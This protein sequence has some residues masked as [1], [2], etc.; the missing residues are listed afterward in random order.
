MKIRYA[1]VTAGI[2]STA[3]VFSGCRVVEDCQETESTE[4]LKV[5]D[6]QN[7]SAKGA[8]IYGIVNKIGTDKITIQD[9]IYTSEGEIQ[10]SGKIQEIAVSKDTKLVIQEVQEELIQEE[11]TQEEVIQIEEVIQDHKIISDSN[12]QNENV[13]QIE[14]DSMIDQEAITEDH[15]STEE[16]VDEGEEISLDR[17]AEQSEIEIQIDDIEIGDTVKIIYGQDGNVEQIV[18]L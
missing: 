3:A 7:A 12:G 18:K 2:L 14:E 17:I 15:A 8:P 6:S 1:A 11:T 16:V 13:I 9:G 10:L 5:E 4:V